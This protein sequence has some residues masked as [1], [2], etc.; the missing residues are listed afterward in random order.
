MNAP[1]PTW[2]RRLGTLLC[3]AGFSTLLGSCVSGE[4]GDPGGSCQSTRSYFLSEVWGPV[5]AQTCVN[6]HAPGGQAQ[7]QNARFQ[8]LPASYPDF[9]DTNLANIASVANILYDNGGRQMSVLLAKPLGMMSHG[10]GQIFR[11]GS[12][13]YN[14]IA[15]LLE[16][17]N[18]DSRGNESCRD[19]GSLAAPSGVTL[20]DWGA[21]LRKAALDQLGRLPTPE[22]T[23]QAS[24]DEAG[25][26]ATLATMLQEDAFYAR[27]RTA[28]NDLMLTDRYVT[29]D[30]CDQRALNLIS[31][32]D[33]PNRGAYDGG[34][35]EGL[36]CCGTDRDNPSCV[37]VRR[38]FLEANNAIAREP[39]NLFEHVVR[40]NRPFSEVLTADYV[41][42]NPQ[43]AYI[44]GLQDQ[45]DFGGS[46]D[47]NQLREARIT[48]TRRYTDT[49]SETVP[50]PHAGVL[51]TPT[52]L[53][54]YPTTDTNRNR[55]RARIVQSYFLA[56]DILKVGE[57][58]IDPT[59]GEALVQTPTMNYGPC[60]MCHRINDPIA[61]AFRGFFPSDGTQWRYDPHDAWY[62][63]MFPPGFAGEN[64]P[65]ASYPSA[66]QWLAPRVASDPRF[67]TS[68]VK[69]VYKSLTGREPLS[70][71]T[72]TADPLYAARAAAWNQQDR[73]FRAIGRRFVA[74]NMN[75]R[76]VVIE[77]IKS[78]IFRA[79][80]GPST[81]DAARVA[82]LAGLGTGRLLTP[83]LLTA[84][85]RAIAGFRWVRDTTRQDEW[86]MNDFYL[87]YG[88][89]NSDTVITRATDPSGIIVNVA[90]RM[91]TEVAC[92]GTAFD[93]TRPQAQRRF[94]TQVE[95]D[96]V[97]ESAGHAVPESAATIRR[98]IVELHRLI[99][100]ENLSPDSPE[101]DRTFNLFLETWREASTSGSNALPSSC[102]ATV[103]LNTGENLEMSAR[104]TD[105]PQGT[106]RAWMAVLTYLFSDYKFIYE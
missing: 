43:S 68:A 23:A 31:G 35:G 61:G 93:F 59:A 74:N 28:F 26:E 73:I 82:S 9:A 83:E 18:S 20:L 57:R 105:D 79:V 87:P 15:G 3:A 51:T 97:P 86:L 77:M 34:G 56:T 71:P 40:N 65:G 55:H 92:R 11:E 63:D 101:I 76:T 66:L 6:C 22:E 94:F 90:A 99:L 85:V 67:V 102:R 60:V 96:V 44:Y 42:V 1:R 4:I 47:P 103:D 38:N 100:G 13:E 5:M 106:I 88:G 33:F 89:I 37:D 49:R 50:F 104:I 30:G 95:R 48:Y 62:T 8:L 27:W 10:G 39:I 54:R 24:V 17:M 80:A 75:F 12:P 19:Y 41:L 69:F 16:R 2:S 78:P 81:M 84:R 91:A 53:N 7:L 45:V 32:R 36:D 98:N 52:F 64:M 58:P 21:T 46:Y 72:D 25:F 14:A 70:Y 29:R